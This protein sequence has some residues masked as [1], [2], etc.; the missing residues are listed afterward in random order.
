[1]NQNPECKRIRLH[2]TK[3]YQSFLFTPEKIRIFVPTN[4]VIMKIRILMVLIGLALLV[5]PTRAQTGKLYGTDNQ[6]TSNFVTQVFQDQDGFIWIATRNGLNVY[7]GYQF[8]TL[9]R[10]A[11]EN[12]G[13][14]NNYINCIA[15]DR[16]GTIFIGT[17]NGIEAYDGSRFHII[18]MVSPDGQKVKTYITHIMQRRN[19][20]ILACSSGYGIMRIQGHRAKSL[21]GIF[22]RY[23]YVSKVM[24]DHT[25]RLWIIT[26]DNRLV[27]FDGKHLVRYFDQKD[28]N[29]SVR[30]I[31]EDRQ[32]NIYIIRFNYGLYC[33][34]SGRQSFIRIR[35]V[36]SLPAICLTLSH[37][38]N[39]MLG[40]DGQGIYIFNPKKKTLEKNPYYSREIDLSKTKVCS[41][42]ED[43]YG[44]VWLG[45]LQK[46]VFMQPAERVQF[47]YMGYRLGPENVIGSNCVTSL[48]ID[49]KN[50]IW[51]GTDKD[52]LYELD[53]HFKLIRHYTDLPLS[54]LTLAEDAKGHIWTGS[55]REGC[56]YL[57]PTSGKWHP[58]SLGQEGELSV[59]DIISDQQG[60]L[61]FATM[62]KGL[63][64]LDAKNQTV[65]TYRM[66]NGADRN[67]HKNSI[68]NNFLSKLELS[69]D[70][71]RLYIAS[72][73]GLCCLDLQRNS[74]TSTF[75]NNCPDYGTFSRIIRED[76]RGRVWMGTNDGL[77]CYDLKR[78][79][80]YVYT[81]NDGLP[82]N[83]VAIIETDRHGNLWIGTNHGLCKLNPYKDK[84]MNFY[85]DNGLQSNEFSDGASCKSAG[86][87]LMVFGGTGG[88]TWFNPDRIQQAR[89][90]AS[91]KI[92]GFLV[93]NEHVVAGMKSGLYE[94][95][96][97][98]VIN[99]DLFN[100]AW[101]DNSFSVQ[102]STL[103][104]DNPDHITYLYSINGEKWKRLQPG[105]NEITFSHLSAGKW[106][107]Q[108][109]AM[110]NNLESSVRSFTVVVHPAWY[111]S[112]WARLV[113]LLFL[114]GLVWLL[115]RNR[116]HK[117]QT[118]LRM[119]E[120][121]HAEQLGEAKIKAF[122]NI[123]HEIR[124]PMTLIITPLMSLMK[125][126]KDP[127]RRSI[128]VI[129]RRNAERIL[130]LV[131]QMMDLRKIDKGLMAM[132]MK[133]TD[134][135]TFIDDIYQMF[136]QEAKTRNIHLSF[137]SDEKVIE[138]YID[139][140]NFDKILMNLLSN[141]FKFTP[142]GGHVNITLTHDEKNVKLSIKDDGEKIPEDKLETIFRRFYQTPSKTNEVIPGTGIGL[143][144]T[145]SLVE[146]HHGKIVA[147]NNEGEKGC[148]FIVTLP[149]GCSHLQPEELAEDDEDEVQKEEI[150]MN[151]WE[152]EIP[153]QPEI[154]KKELF[155]KLST[156]K[157][158]TIVIVE[159]DEE[160]RNY[161][162]SQ[163]EGDFN[164]L[165]C[166]NGEEALE[167]V[168]KEIPALVIS[169]IMMP[170]MDGNTLCAKIKSNV[171]TNHIPV[172]LLTAKN[173]DEDRL[174][175]LETGADAYLVK[176]FNMDILRRTITNLLKEREVL[177]NKFAGN[178]NLG[179]NVEPVDLES[180]DRKLLERILSVVN[181]N[182][183]NPDLSVEMIA[184]EVGISRVHL[185][186]KM[187]ELTNQ[188]PHD[189]IRNVRLKQ[190]ASLLTNGHQNISEVMFACGFNNAAS[191]STTFKNFYGRSPRDYMKEHLQEEKN[192]TQNTDS[193]SDEA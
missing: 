16:Q 105:V 88:I 149:L 111:A 37:K 174:E 169:D 150:R 43:Q 98:A 177:R 109:K 4:L 167:L 71:K 95:T 44:N 45:M 26:E 90:H 146:L 168:Y 135:V 153:T 116:K 118:R 155:E 154:S 134:L 6:L 20:D 63:I 192:D 163:L 14:G 148:E 83:G 99:T 170:I 123:S 68:P 86:G 92:T 104:F 77:Y 184:K 145:R 164:I 5:V 181:K 31:C 165:V 57:D 84:T 40:T 41:I 125:E 85:V 108:V 96:D 140:G 119:Q 52:G 175:G 70:G 101:A 156:R 58:E 106:H 190:A 127:H 66:A 18:E 35:Q 15:Q 78:H 179:G 13:L 23:R 93:G 139:R 38:G 166:G 160:I 122:M 191:F 187:K 176:P 80:S 120:H 132:H 56:G 126:D 144:L 97:K 51:V 62:G 129:M 39:L 47:G 34:P 138:A 143:D 2:E 30:D 100:L 161:L 115:I 74:W 19:G 89:W 117:E 17:N 171:N 103:T 42:L 172:I 182:I 12:Y 9:S 53:N 189:F 8:R 79:S 110:N 1:M 76:N 32:G 54:V 193:G 25:G 61:W 33:K 46:G 173:R 7:D 27:V 141:A 65:K 162:K 3:K 11:P 50:H 157:R 36:G 112:L 91:V 10:E 102:L 178:E 21:G 136:L 107:F 59:F 124:T 82:D 48:V 113:Y 158:Q 183:G 67:R 87:N 81:I 188:T 73:V 152:T 121:I 94:I 147:Q 22:R 28:K 180:P 75:G 186:R 142:A 159:D 128:Y 72:S 131:N 137:S 114:A 60:N 69:H 55:W 185:H 133:K 130:H 49:R 64:R 24:E 29:G 151:D